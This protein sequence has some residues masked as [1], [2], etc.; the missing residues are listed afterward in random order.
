VRWVRTRG[1]GAI[2][3]EST[4]LIKSRWKWVCYWM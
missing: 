4:L 1:T 3:G 2:A